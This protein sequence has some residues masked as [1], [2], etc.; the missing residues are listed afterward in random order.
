MRSETT[1]YSIVGHPVSLSII[2]LFTHSCAIQCDKGQD[3]KDP[4]INKLGGQ[5]IF[6]CVSAIMH[7]LHD[8]D[9]RVSCRSGETAMGGETWSWSPCSVHPVGWGLH[10]HWSNTDMVTKWRSHC[11]QSTV[12]AHI[13]KWAN[14]PCMRVIW[15]NFQLTFCYFHT[16]TKLQQNKASAVNADA[17]NW[18]RTTGM[19]HIISFQWDDWPQ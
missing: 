13:C 8:F 11:Q 19:V 6:V 9:T 17:G 7:I 2:V 15:A 12:S 14:V 1:T 4:K 10:N 16:K 18:S 3:T 5:E